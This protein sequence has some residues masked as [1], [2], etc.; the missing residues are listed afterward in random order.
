MCKQP[1]AVLPRVLITYVQVCTWNIG[2]RWGLINSRGYVVRKPAMERILFI[3]NVYEHA[4]SIAWQWARCRE[5]FTVTKFQRESRFEISSMGIFNCII[6]GENLLN[7]IWVEEAMR[8][9]K[10]RRLVWNLANFRA[11]A[12]IWYAMWISCKLLRNIV[13]LW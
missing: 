1:L 12:A 9:E 10:I 7:N 5:V 4:L 8:L 11:V 6:I 3:V 2:I 13:Y